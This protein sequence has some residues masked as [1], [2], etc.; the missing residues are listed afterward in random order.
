M[1]LNVNRKNVKCGNV[2]IIMR[3]CS[4][5][6]AFR[7]CYLSTRISDDTLQNQNGCAL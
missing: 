6:D 3:R 1:L 4:A 2:K 7:Y 5:D